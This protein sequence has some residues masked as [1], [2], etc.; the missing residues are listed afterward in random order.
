[1]FTWTLKI[2]TSTKLKQTQIPAGIQSKQ[3]AQLSLIC[4]QDKLLFSQ[5]KLTRFALQE[6]IMM[7]FL[8][9]I[10]VRLQIYMSTHFTAEILWNVTTRKCKFI[11]SLPCIVM[12]DGSKD[13]KERC[14]GLF[15]CNVLLFVWNTL[16]CFCPICVS[17]VTCIDRYIFPIL[18]DNKNFPQNLLRLFPIKYL[19]RPNITSLHIFVLI[20]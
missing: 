4:Y 20:D 19:E 18:T 3:T 5:Y 16:R 15:Y 13:V 14:C 7:L 17:V 9:K 6:I 11:L 2:W 1:V 12:P 10:Q 8:Q